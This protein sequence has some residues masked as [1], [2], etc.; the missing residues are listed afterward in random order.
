MK[1]KQMLNW[2]L[3]AELLELRKA[4]I[5]HCRAVKKGCALWQEGDQNKASAAILKSVVK[6]EK[7]VTEQKA[8][9]DTRA[10]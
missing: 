3:E 9:H 1:A 5:D 6:L 8:R 10:S 7:V 4:L 2:Q